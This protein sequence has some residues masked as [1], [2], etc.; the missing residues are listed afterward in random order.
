MAG[1]RV[2][3]LAKEFGISSK[4]MLDQL[5]KMKIKSAKS[6]ASMLSDADVKKVR[7]ELA[8]EVK[9]EKD[10]KGH[11]ET[12]IVTK[13]QVEAEKRHEE[14]ERERRRAVEKERATREAERAKRKAPHE[15]AA[16]DGAD[17]QAH[18][19]TARKAAPASPFESLAHQIEDER[20]RVKREAAA[21]K[22][23]AR[24]EANA[25]EVAK[26]QAV[27]AAIRER[28]NGG[29]HSTQHTQQK[30]KPV[31]TPGRSTKAFS[32][33]LS[34]IESEQKRMAEQSKAKA[35]ARGQRRGD[36]R[37]NQHRGG[38]KKHQHTEQIVPELE[39]NAPEGKDRYA[40]MAVQVE[41]LQRDKVLAEARA[42]VAAATTHE[43]EGRRKKRKEKREA[44]A[45][46]KAEQAAIKK[47]LDP[48]LVLDDSVVE[49]PQ[50]ATVAE[51]AEA[52]GVQP[53][54][55]IKRLFM[56][57]QALT[58]TQSM[59][60]DLIELV[61]DDLGR[62]VRI[63]SPEEEFAV[64]YHD[65]EDQLEP[66]PPVVTVMGHVD[67]GKTSL[68]DA[69]RHTGV[70]SSEAGGITQ[71]IGASVVH[72]NGRQITFIDTPGHE[73]FTAMRARGAQVTDVI[74]L[75]VAADD[76]VMPQTIEAINHAKAANV[77]IVVAVN[78]IDKP[79]AN[80]DR[81]RQELVEYGVVPE[82]WGGKNMF[83]NVSA[84]KKLH[85]DDLL[86][87]ILLQAD[88]LELKANPNA[89][90][91]GFV[92]ESKLDKGR[93]P[94]ATVLVQRGTLHPGDYV[95][96]GTSYGRVRAL[97]DP[98]GKRFKEAKPSDPAEVLGLNSVPVAGD[99]FRV[100]ENERDAKKL[101]E[102]RALRE[103]RA[104]QD[105]RSHMSLDE[106]FNRIEEGKQTDLNLIV[107]ADVQG[108][109]EALRDAF[110]KMDQSEVRINI[111]HSAVGGITETDVTLAAASDAIIIGFNVRPTGKSKQLAE[112]EKVD[113]RLYRV[114]YQAIEDI[115]AAR[116][117]L[118]KPD[119]VEEDTG[120][121]EIRELFHVP[122][123]GTVAGCYV[124]EGE[125]HRDDKVRVVRD[126]TVVFEGELASMRRF[127]DDV[128]SV[129]QGYECGLGVKGFQD[130]KVGDTIEGYV[131]KEV[132]RTE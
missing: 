77:P 76:G 72:I 57:G 124:N 120:V 74:V 13:E 55:V 19:K 49:V 64:V 103:R 108:S 90:A 84:K 51:F 89:E 52:L 47:G 125:L 3:E 15:S 11:K 111:V 93:G 105:K 56:L 113:I 54:D 9:V 62:K 45:R 10:A 97:I 121:A 100:F 86:E 22:K 66:R 34:Q 79:G 83:V 33:L 20:E 75:V 99:E 36:T 96:A 17:K 126:G 32:S 18:G 115:N 116:V 46:E 132:E 82:E 68:L 16:K 39:Q 65:T 91:S 92:I 24:V 98:H 94:V 42:A 41:K 44:E 35:E 59:S 61:A 28:M 23:R 6:H 8:G 29:H 131:V 21:A 109:I 73:A 31:P 88:V 27:E 5:H 128:K 129:K 123:V 48:K 80:P 26:K 101:A 4:D 114:I 122:K 112:K 1:M 38:K 85:I 104:A 25:R 107:K 110:D 71:R 118:L 69:I 40:K 37:N 30:H 63:V 60:D 12:K 127:K 58:L 81:V 70:A 14:E 43:G 130:L 67:H 7:K 119:I 95:V 87:T 50:N 2:Q 117:G 102:E 106:L 53:N 78:K